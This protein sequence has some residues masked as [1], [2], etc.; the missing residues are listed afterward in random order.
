MTDVQPR[1][2]PAVSPPYRARTP[3]RGSRVLH[4]LRTTD[5]K[6]IGIHYMVTAFV[7]SWSAARWRC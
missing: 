1:V 6:D 2:T 7:S 4:V 5:P 3:E